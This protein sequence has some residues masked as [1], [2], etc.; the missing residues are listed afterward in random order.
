MLA[1]PPGATLAAEME[2]RRLY[3]AQALRTMGRG[4]VMDHMR[5]VAMGATKVAQ[6]RQVMNRVTQ[7]VVD[8]DLEAAKA[9]YAEDAVVE[10]PDE[11]TLRGREA[12]G[13]WLGR[14]ATAFPDG[15]YE[16]VAGHEADSTAIDEG[17]FVGTHTGPLTGPDGQE[18]PPTGKKIRLRACD[19]ATVEDGVITSHRF[20]YD[21]MA[22]LEQLG[23]SEQ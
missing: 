12:I 17:F 2:A 5:R 15:T 8:N 16:L 11:G 10:T 22:L 21:Q 4:A 9:C 7:A 20:Y 13:D 18:I 1:G 6:A 14:F 19:C 3:A 23:L